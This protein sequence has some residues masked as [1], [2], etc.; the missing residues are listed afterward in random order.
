MIYRYSFNKSR[1]GCWYLSSVVNIL[2]LFAKY[3]AT[4]DIYRDNAYAGL[5]RVNFRLQTLC[6]TAWRWAQNRFSYLAGNML[7]KNGNIMPQIVMSKCLLMVHLES[8]WVCW[9]LDLFYWELSI[10]SPIEFHIFV[11]LCCFWTWKLV[12]QLRHQFHICYQ[13]L[14]LC[15]N[16]LESTNCVVALCIILKAFLVNLP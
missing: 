3:D 12:N 2:L 15:V 16:H 11:K 5:P 7:C 13:N 14:N 1:K 9:C 10:K 8:C 4:W 6:H